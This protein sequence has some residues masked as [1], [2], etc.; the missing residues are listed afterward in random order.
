MIL[1]DNDAYVFEELEQD[2]VLLFTWKH[3]PGLGIEL[4]KDAILEFA[5]LCRKHEPA[6]GVIDACQLDQSSPAVAWLR[7][8]ASEEAQPYDDWWAREVLPIY[9]SAS[10]GQLAVATGDPGAPGEV[11]KPQRDAALR[12]G[13]FPDLDAARAW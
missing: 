9:I 5:A 2:R 11:P 4:F 3:V 10:L 12:M 13:Y 1:H 6:K 8:Q 7:G